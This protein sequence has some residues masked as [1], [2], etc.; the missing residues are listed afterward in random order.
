[1]NAREVLL[2][3]VLETR[4]GLHPDKA[5]IIYAD[6]TYTYAQLDEASARLAAGLQVNGLQRQERVVVCLGNRVGTICAF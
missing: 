4:N 3:D 2:Q 5:A 6:E 1:M